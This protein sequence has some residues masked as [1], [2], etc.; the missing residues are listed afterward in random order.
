LTRWKGDWNWKNG[1]CFADHAAM[2][3]SLTR[4]KGD[5]NLSRQIGPQGNCL[6]FIHWPDEK[7]IETLSGFSTLYEC[8]SASFIDPMK[9][10]LKLILTAWRMRKQFCFIHWPDEKG[11]E[12]KAPPIPASQ[13]HL[14][15]SLT[16]WKGDWNWFAKNYRLNFSIGFIHW[17]DEKGIE[18]KFK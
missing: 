9:R 12:T 7:G 16:R 11:I 10:G 3:H 13:D 2:L 15:H 8:Q 5:W 14:L 17:P 1:K 4:W 18:T 6:S